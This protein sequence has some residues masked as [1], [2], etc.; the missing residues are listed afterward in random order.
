MTY[1]EYKKV[2]IERK[3]TLENWR[4]NY[5]Q[6]Y[7]Q[8]AMI[9]HKI[10]GEA[11]YPPPIINLSEYRFDAA[12]TQGDKPPHDVT[13]EEARKFIEEA[14]FTIKTW[15]GVSWN[16]YSK[17]GASFV[18]TDLKTIRT[19][20]KAEEYDSKIQKLIEVFEECIKRMKIDIAR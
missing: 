16:Y 20:F 19:A 18:R 12:H 13:E 2:Y 17:A 5:V 4:N 6:S 9:E 1:S 10:K 3:Q 8:A 11:V 15:G 7:L 14:Y